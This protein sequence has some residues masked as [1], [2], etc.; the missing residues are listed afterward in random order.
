MV[1]S[2]NKGRPGMD[3]WSILVLGSLRVDLNANYDR[4]LELP[5]QLN[6]LHEIPGLGCFDSDKRYRL[7]NL[8]RQYQTIDASDHWTYQYK[9][10]SSRL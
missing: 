10:Y 7:P 8:N 4:T 9:S 2:I 5:N 6:T 1:V 3:Q